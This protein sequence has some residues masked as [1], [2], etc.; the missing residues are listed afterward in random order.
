[1]GQLWKTAPL[2]H[3]PNELFG[4]MIIK[5]IYIN[6]ISWQEFIQTLVRRQRE[7][8]VHI[9]LWLSTVELKKPNHGQII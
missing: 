7:I 2:S 9:Q 5:I 1:M 6:R 4:K 8:A 3:F